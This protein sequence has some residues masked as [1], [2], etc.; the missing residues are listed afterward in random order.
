MTMKKRKSK[1]FLSLI[2]VIIIS[3]AFLLFELF[4]FLIM[5]IFS[6]LS[7]EKCHVAKSYG[8]QKDFMLELSNHERKKGKKRKNKIESENFFFMSISIFFQIWT[9]KWFFCTKLNVFCP[10]ASLKSRHGSLSSKKSAFCKW[11]LIYFDTTRKKNKLL[12]LYIFFSF[13]FLSE[14]LQFF[15]SFLSFCIQYTLND[16][17][18]CLRNWK[19]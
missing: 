1:I 15:V 7:T 19:K 10:L 9:M 11:K 3:K 13:L 18:V 6:L 12:R 14:I 5:K 16:E 17:F 8:C 2:N 4:I